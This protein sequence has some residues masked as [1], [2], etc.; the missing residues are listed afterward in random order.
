V[1]LPAPIPSQPQPKR[2]GKRAQPEGSVLPPR[3][4]QA[5]PPRSTPPPPLRDWMR[6]KTL[7]T[8]IHKNPTRAGPQILTKV[9]VVLSPR[10]YAP[11]NPACKYFATVLNRVLQ[12]SKRT[13][14]VVIG[15]GRSTEKRIQLESL[16]DMYAK[17]NKRALI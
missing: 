3:A 11:W 9:L 10:L 2:V 8:G 1:T 16:H 14:I 6:L 5:S 17:Y 15:N 7:H 12:D 13:E 4:M